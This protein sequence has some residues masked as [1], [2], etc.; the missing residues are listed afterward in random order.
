MFLNHHF[1]LTGNKRK[2]SGVGVGGG[3]GPVFQNS[4]ARPWLR[5][6]FASP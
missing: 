6:P 4:F 5:H 3:R 1:A 2:P